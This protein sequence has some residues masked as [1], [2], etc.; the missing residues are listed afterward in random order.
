MAT[1]SD[2]M[3][4]RFHFK[5]YSPEGDVLADTGEE[6]TT[7]I[8]GMMQTDPEGL[9]QFL[10]GKEAGYTGR[11]IIEQAFG[12]SIPREEA[13]QRFPKEQLGENVQKG[14]MFA[15]Q[16]PGQGDI[17]MTVMDI[18]DDQVIVLM[19]HPLA[20]YDI[21]FDIEVIEVRP[22][23]QADIEELQRQFGG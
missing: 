14:M 5:M 2:G 22:H 8:H 6:P 23:T 18:Q 19:G 7:Y 17:P 13:L 1:I 20:G 11:T 10:A 4:V 16:I 21:P 15:A 12:P 9:C 3:L